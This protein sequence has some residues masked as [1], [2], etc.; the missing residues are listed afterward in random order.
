MLTNCSATEEETKSKKAIRLMCLP[1]YTSNAAKQTF[2]CIGGELSAS[3]G[4]VH[5]KQRR[6]ARIITRPRDGSRDL[7]PDTAKEVEQY[8][9]RGAGRREKMGEW[10]ADWDDGSAR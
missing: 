5:L 7:G 6:S 1:A 9:F 4:Q 8:P 10:A 3:D 2:G